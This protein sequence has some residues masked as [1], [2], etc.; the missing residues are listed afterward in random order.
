MKQIIFCREFTYHSPVS[1]L[2][3]PTTVFSSNYWNPAPITIRFLSPLTYSKVFTFYL[4]TF[5]TTTSSPEL[6]GGTYTCNIGVAFNSM[7]VLTKT[8]WSLNY[9]YYETC[10]PNFLFMTTLNDPLP[11]PCMS[12]DCICI[13]NTAMSL[14][15]PNELNL[16]L[17]HLT[18][19]YLFLS[20]NFSNFSLHPSFL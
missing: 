17:Q 7:S 9:L 6:V 2:Y 13:S 12:W 8:T 14:L 16:F 3:P 5:S 1:F 11:H 20:K 15:S 19:T 10:C 18:S 4:Q